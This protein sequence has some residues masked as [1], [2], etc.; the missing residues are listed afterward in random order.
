MRI[1]PNA[2]CQPVLVLALWLVGSGVAIGSQSNTSL[3]G[4]NTYLG[5]LMIGL[6]QFVS[7]RLQVTSGRLNVAVQYNNPLI[8]YVNLFCLLNANVHTHTHTHTGPTAL[9]GRLSDR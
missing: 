3:H 8:E 4:Y 6:F 9:H 2:K 7:C 1:A 5:Q